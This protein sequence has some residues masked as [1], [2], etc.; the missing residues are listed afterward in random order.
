MAAFL[1]AVEGISGLKPRII[2]LAISARLSVR[3]HPAGP[4][5]SADLYMLSDRI[6][7]LAHQVA[8]EEDDKWAAFDE[9]MRE[10]HRLCDEVPN[11]D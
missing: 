8:R 7:R 6:G 9:T 10:V 2:W 4:M 5:T 3:N 11:A 1:M